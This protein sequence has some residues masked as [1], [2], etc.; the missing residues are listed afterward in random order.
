M[1]RLPTGTVTLLFTDIEGSTDLAQRLGDRRYGKVL[2]E[3]RRLLREAFAEGNGQE[4]S[5]QGDALLVA[6]SSARS[7]LG[8]A[9]A[10][11][12][13]LTNHA[14]PEGASLRVRMG[15]HT[16][17]PFSEMGGYVGLD[18]HRVARI[19]SAGYGGQILLSKAVEVLAAPELPPGA[20]LRD[21]GNHRLK[22][23]KE[24]EHLF[25]V[26]HPD[27]PTD[28]P[29]LKSLVALPNNLPRQLTSFIGRER[30]IAETERVLSTAPLVSLV[31]PG[32]SGKTRLALQLAAHVLADYRDGVWLVELA[33]LFDPAIIPK[34]AAVA[35]GVREEPGRPLIATLTEFARP[36]KLLLL[37][38]NVE[39]LLT[40]CAEFA[41]SLLRACPDLRILATSREP[42]GILGE[43][44]W[45]VPPLSLP[46]RRYPQSVD[47]VM[48]C[49]AARLFVERAN[50]NQPR[51]TVTAGNAEAI[52]QIC[53]RLDGIPLA[54]ELAAAWVNVLAPAQIAS[55]LDD[56]FRLLARG[57]RTALPRHQTLRATM[58]WSYELLSK[59]EK[60]L[61]QRLSVFS[62]GWTLEAAEVICG[63][64]PSR[65]AEILDLLAHLV[66]KSL[67]N[68]D[69]E[70]G[71]AR[72]RQ[73]ETVREYGRDKLRESGEAIDVGN[74][75][76]DWYTRLAE[77][78][79]PEL[80]G[81]TQA[82][83]L[84]RLEE[85][86]DNL[87]AALTW[88][89]ERGET[90]AGLRLAVAIQRF[91][92]VRGYLAE[93][94]RWIE[95]L[96]QQS[97]GVA[98]AIRAR[99]LFGAGSLAVHGQGDYVAGRSFY[100]QSLVL[101]RNMGDQRQIAD[102]LN[103]LGVLAGA[104]GD[105]AAARARHEESLAI[106]RK[107]G[108]QWGIGVSLHNLGRVA[109]REGRYETAAALFQESL[110][111]W[112]TGG[113][114]QHIAMALNN[115]GLATTWL[116][117]YPSARTCLL[118]ALEI[119]RKVGDKRQMGDSL[120][121]FSCLAAAEG[122]AMQAARLFGAAEAL[123]GAINVPLPPADRPIFH[124]W[125]DVARTALGDEAFDTAFA[126]GRMLSPQ[127]ALDEAQAVAGEA[128]E[129]HRSSSL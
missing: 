17:E 113:D 19:C 98:A 30:D 123:R 27:L 75:H 92:L 122:K 89:M 28:F 94:R 116:A 65:T 103:G 66:G 81:E 72:Y 78:A 86:H 52:S 96:L 4:I 68:V 33:P 105:Q 127:E 76:R 109:L 5:S 26:V 95:T 83:W 99:A 87:R 93:G 36:R 51:F 118:E 110:V 3:H 49:E 20:S 47:R 106:R 13:A 114:K 111:L 23:L 21:L 34:A 100:E 8:T 90:E 45:Q 56:R 57:S 79:A 91:W 97:E 1:P 77:R 41:D 62:N 16:G 85:E 29:P 82:T 125:M 60:T 54:I 121:A 112:R 108:D 31:G 9:V 129:T 70:G 80:I 102:V 67:V 15:L 64:T 50:L 126:Q 10:A 18:V 14:W 2:E 46:D 71:E 115:L 107:S 32:G 63:E 117:N 124:H 11:Q 12:R 69:T 73:L 37:L 53:T 24:P 58:D 59:E 44:I 61:L 119:L 39:H 74:R 101:W 6:F 42:L 43:V 55:R 22:D 84:D 104:L 40:G 48:Q 88:S 25:Q 35:L 120:E 7:A 128:K 38:D